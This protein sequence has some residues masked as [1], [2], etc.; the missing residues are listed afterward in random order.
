MAGLTLKWLQTIVSAKQ[1]Y[2]IFGEIR[3][4]ATILGKMIAIAAQTPR[5]IDAVRRSRW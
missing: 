4:S 3:F 5:C 2:A 1:M